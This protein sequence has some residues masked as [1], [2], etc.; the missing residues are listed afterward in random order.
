M[1]QK[2]STSNNQSGQR[3]M[4]CVAVV[5]LTLTEGLPADMNPASVRGMSMTVDQIV[6]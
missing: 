5:R 2:T 4:S 6:E 3:Q 1:G